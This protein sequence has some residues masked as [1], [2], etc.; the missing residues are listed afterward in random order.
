MTSEQSTFHKTACILCESNCG[1][2]V[3]LDGRSFERIRGNKD[4]VGSKGYTC[5]KALRLDYYQ[6]SRDRL[7]LPMRRRADGTHEQVSW[8]TAIGVNS[9]GT[10]SPWRTPSLA[11]AA[12]LSRW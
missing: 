12:S 4:H 10:A 1:I 6:N 11:S 9:I 3:R 7:T 8:E 5:E 2:E